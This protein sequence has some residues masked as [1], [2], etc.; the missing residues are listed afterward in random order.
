[1]VIDISQ[2][3]PVLQLQWQNIHVRP[4]CFVVILQPKNR[5]TTLYI[6]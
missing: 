3:T 6:L 1:M 5:V 2:N 4:L